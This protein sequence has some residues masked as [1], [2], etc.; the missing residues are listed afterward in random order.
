MLESPDF[1]PKTVRSEID[2]GKQGSVF[3][4]RG[5][6]WVQNKRSSHPT[7]PPC[8]REG[9]RRRLRDVHETVIFASYS[10]L[11][12]AIAVVMDFN[13]KEL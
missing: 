2:G 8:P 1:E 6:F 9:A 13:R 12:R 4:E 11:T 5:G 3:H 7:P 10:A